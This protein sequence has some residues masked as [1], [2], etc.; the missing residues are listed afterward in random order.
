MYLFGHLQGF[1]EQRRIYQYVRRH[2]HV[3]FPALPSYQAFNRRLNLL[4][5]AFSELI[6]NVLESRVAQLAPA[7]DRLIDSLPVM[8]AKGT[9]SSTARVAREVADKGF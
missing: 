1:H 6:G 5:P 8:L 7:A 3:W 2:W 9:R 4:A